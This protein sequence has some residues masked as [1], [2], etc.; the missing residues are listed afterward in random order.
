M[1]WTLHIY[2]YCDIELLSIP[3]IENRVKVAVEGYVSALLRLCTSI[4]SLID[5]PALPVVVVITCDAQYPC[6]VELPFLN[7]NVVM[8]LFIILSR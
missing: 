3:C 5:A 6:Q 1:I 4:Q 7:P 8:L 2:I